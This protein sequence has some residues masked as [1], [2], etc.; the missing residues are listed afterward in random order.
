MGR[1]G[2]L[3]SLARRAA[4][5][6]MPKA[7]P[8]RISYLH[9]ERGITRRA[10]LRA[11]AGTAA[12]AAVLSGSM[13]LLMPAGAV[14]AVSALD[15]CREDNAKQTLDDFKRCVDYPLAEY[16]AANDV[17]PQIEQHLA[18]ATKPSARKR[19]QKNLE[20]ARRD[21]AR[22][23][24]TIENCNTHYLIDQAYGEEACR[25]TNGGPGGTPSGGGPGPSGCDS[26]YKLCGDYCCDTFYAE[27]ITCNGMSICCRIGGMCCNS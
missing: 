1:R 4:R 15:M 13:D 22:A 23:L 20:R 18:E 26:G 10:A 8:P 27:C 5:A 6:E 2:W 3:D 19:L 14:A 9:P 25:S 16:E 12:G 11:A 21:R 17:I 7:I 24:R